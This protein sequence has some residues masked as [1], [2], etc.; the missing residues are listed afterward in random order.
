MADYR[1][2]IAMKFNRTQLDRTIIALINNGFNKKFASN[3]LRL[4]KIFKPASYT[5]DIEKEVRVYLI[6]QIAN[7]IIE[8]DII[9]KS[10]IYGFLDIDGKY[11]NESK[12]IMDSLIDQEISESEV[13][14]LD[15]TISDQLKYCTI[16]D[17]ANELIEELQNLQTENFNSLSD[18]IGI[19]E[20]SIET[21]NREIKSAR[22]SIEDSKQDLN[23]S[24][25]GFLNYLD[26]L[27]EKEKNP[28]TKVKTGIQYLNRML[29]G[30][31]ER[32]RLYCVLATAKAGKSC[33]L[34]NCAVWAKIQELNDLKP[35]D[36]TKKPVI[37]YLTME[38]SVEETVKRLWNL[39]FGNDAS[40]ATT[41]KMSAA[42]RLES[43]GIFTPNNPDL[44]ELRIWYRSNRSI[45]TADLTIMLDDLKK[46]GSECVFLILDYLKRIRPAEP[47]K[48]LRLELSNVTNELK[49]IAVENDIPVLTAMQLNRTAFA[50]I[51]AAT[52]FEE[53]V[54]ASEKLGASNVGESIDIIQNVDLAMIINRMQKRLVNDDR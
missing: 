7:I 50:E 51:E 52:S 10:A 26:K 35:K 18:Q 38:N 44:P 4:F 36:P 42:R 41:D 15:A 16:Q 39:K 12:E 9:E 48:D 32:G 54:R 46:E 1:T 20:N 40:L 21:V 33:F 17:K 30:G 53:Q 19:L 3:V 2:R 37:V 27:I 23:L 28:S 13:V 49:T 5:D 24:N 29:N 45:S 25:N 47:N 43:A 6:K 22:E 14:A 34:L 11:Y 31:F 8:K